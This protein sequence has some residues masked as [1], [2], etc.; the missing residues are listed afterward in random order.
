MPNMN[1]TPEWGQSCAVKR[2]QGHKNHW[3]LVM[4][5]IEALTF[6]S[7]PGEKITSFNTKSKCL[8]NEKQFF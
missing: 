1:G 2:L 4:I 7:L 6:S 5:L 8:V 3:C